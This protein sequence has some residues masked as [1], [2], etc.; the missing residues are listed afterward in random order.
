M[1]DSHSTNVSNYMEY[2]PERQDEHFDRD[3]LL[4]ILLKKSKELETAQQL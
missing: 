1:S 3:T 4:G 2:T